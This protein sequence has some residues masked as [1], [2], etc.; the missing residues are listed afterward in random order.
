MSIKKFFDY[1]LTI[2]LICGLALFCSYISCHYTRK[3]IVTAREGNM[4]IITDTVGHEWE[5]VEDSLNIND[6][7]KMRMNTNGTDSIITDD[8]I[9]NYKKIS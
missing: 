6:I 7:V 9:E 4:V 1:L 5:I 8:I 3:G 2:V